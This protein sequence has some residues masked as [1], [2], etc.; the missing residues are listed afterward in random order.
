[1]TLYVFM[2]VGKLNSDLKIS[3]LR[4]CVT[5][6][7]QN[8]LFTIESSLYYSEKPSVIESTH[9]LDLNCVCAIAHNNIHMTQCLGLTIVG[10][11]RVVE[12]T[13]LEAICLVR[14]LSTL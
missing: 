14:N 12:H 13:D 4:Y 2:Y 8:T 11:G 5:N 10:C 1:M 3:Q 7:I 9:H 6:V